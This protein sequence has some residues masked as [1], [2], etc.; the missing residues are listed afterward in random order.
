MGG[1]GR[2]LLT[3]D[4]VKYGHFLYIKIIKDLSLLL[5]CD[6][7]EETE[8]TKKYILPRVLHL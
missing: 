4:E 3:E 2:R 8:T 5:S 1:A 6:I 7:T